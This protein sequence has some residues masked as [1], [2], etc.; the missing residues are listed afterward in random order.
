MYKIEINGKWKYYDNIEIDVQKETINYYKWYKRDKQR[1]VFKVYGYDNKYPYLLVTEYPETI[2]E[3]ELL[4]KIWTG[5]IMKFYPELEF[6]GHY[7]CGSSK[8]YFN[9]K[10]FMSGYTK[11]AVNIY[12]RE[13]DDVKWLTTYFADNETQAQTFIDNIIKTTVYYNPI[14]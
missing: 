5:K 3:V 13:D 7:F 8:V 1:T 9:G 4:S 12:S 11:G 2:K 14:F 10:L 6:A